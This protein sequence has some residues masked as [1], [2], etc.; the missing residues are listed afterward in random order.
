MSSMVPD[1]LIFVLLFGSILFGGISLL[2]LLI[3]PDIRS[4]MFT[5]LRGG[6]LCAGAV[7]GAAL[8]FALT[9]LAESGGEQYAAFF[10]HAVFLAGI[11]AV[12]I[13]IVSRQMHEKTQ[14]IAYCGAGAPTPGKE[15][16][17]S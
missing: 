6:L 8:I 4:R 11:M 7:I 15:Q 1:I 14:A 3:F 10:F 9:H 16:N 5:A 17:K 12:G 13:M 2:G